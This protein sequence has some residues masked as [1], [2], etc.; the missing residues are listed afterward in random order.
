MTDH[1]DHTCGVKEFVGSEQ[2]WWLS[3]HCFQQVVVASSVGRILK[4][5]ASC[6]SF[7]LGKLSSASWPPTSLS[8]WIFADMWSS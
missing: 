7:P 6:T 4:S 5:F 3:D 1:K 8:S 2:C